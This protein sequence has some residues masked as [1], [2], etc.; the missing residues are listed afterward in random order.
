RNIYTLGRLWRGG[1]DQHIHLGIKAS[2][3]WYGPPLQAQFFVI[4]DDALGKKAAEGLQ[5]GIPVCI[6]E[7][8]DHRWLV[9]KTDG[10]YYQSDGTLTVKATEPGELQLCQAEKHISQSRC[11]GHG[12]DLAQPLFQALVAAQRKPGDGLVLSGLRGTIHNWNEGE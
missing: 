4:L 10:G 12:G 7:H 6:G 1:N 2:E 5:H 3:G 11:L 8:H 9:S